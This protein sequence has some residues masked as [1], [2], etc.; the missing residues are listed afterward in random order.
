MDSGNNLQKG[1]QG[2]LSTIKSTFNSLISAA[3]KLKIFRLLHLSFGKLSAYVFSTVGLTSKA[4]TISYG[5]PV[6]INGRTLVIRT[7]A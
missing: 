7:D 6:S 2:G 3:D 5:C 1:W 4:P